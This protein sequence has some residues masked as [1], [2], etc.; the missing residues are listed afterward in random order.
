MEKVKRFFAKHIF[1]VVLALSLPAVWTLVVPGFFG[2][3]DDTLIGWLYEMDR[4]VKMFQIP[5]RFVPDLSF[6][7]GYPLF[8]FVYPLPF[9]IGEIFHLFGFSLVDAAK[10]VFGLS[11]PFSMYF[12]YKLL[13]ELVDKPLSL[14]GAVLYVYAPYR[15]TE[16]F[17]R[18]AIGEIVAFVFIPL[19]ALSFIRLTQKD[20]GI[21]WIG[22]SA[23]SIAALVLSHNILAYMFFPFALILLVVL[24]ISA[25]QDK[26]TYLLR[27]FW[28]IILGL[29]ASAYFWFP[30]IYESGL[31]KYSTVY[32]YFDHFA[33][34]K[35][36]ITPY[37]GYGASVPGPY[38][39]MSF[40]IGIIGLLTVVVGGA[41][42][43]KSWKGFGVKEKTVLIWAIGIF[44]LSIFMMNHRSDIL[45]KSI[46]L[47][48]YFQ[49]PWRFL[50]MIV[51]SSPL[52]LIGFSKFKHARI[53]AG[54]I[55]V[56]AIA[57]N[58]L[59]FKPEKFLGRADEYYVD[60][61]IPYP[62]ASAEYRRTSE[63]YLRLPKD[64]L[65]RPSMVYPR[66]YSNVRANLIIEEINPLDA[67]IVTNYPEEFILSYNKYNFP[68]WVAKIDGVGTDIL[69]GVPYGQISLKVPGGTHEVVVEYRE[70]PLRKV[71]NF[72][73]LGAI[74]TAM[75]LV[76]KRK[77]EK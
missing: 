24:I 6:G 34:L 38:D 5:P 58:F 23:L 21:K 47:L 41:L 73:S 30:A 53:V 15:A 35:Q 74:T 71:T 77:N 75:F 33:T 40:Y 13:R 56:A 72:V 7:F 9:Y 61:Y 60:R 57:L 29:L 22:I 65:V 51:F 31:V 48:P 17:V 69:S 49:F 1:L 54:V 19:V 32:N 66:A 4:A 76:I 2:V 11:I 3:S 43:I 18:G 37:F 46:P 45:W 26:I 14:A 59:Y 50:T 70:A 68:G 36:L 12:M 27:S 16:I 8:N 42:A 64:N 55:I 39:G 20:S 52:F 25:K 44:V 28:A 63:E 67:R 10:L 62:A